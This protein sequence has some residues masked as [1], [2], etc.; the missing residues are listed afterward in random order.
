M[1]KKKLTE[2]EEDAKAFESILNEENKKRI[3][4]ILSSID[5]N[6]CFSGRRAME[7]LKMLIGESATSFVLNML[8]SNTLD[9]ITKIKGF[10]PEAQRYVGFLFAKYA[11]KLYGVLSHKKFDHPQMWR[12]IY[13]FNPKYDPDSK[14]FLITMEILQQNGERLVLENSIDDLLQLFSTAVRFVVDQSSKMIKAR[15]DL[16]V[17]ESS[18]VQLRKSVDQLYQ[19]VSKSET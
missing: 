1:G 10:S 12:S 7:S 11:Y 5:E 16:G 4:E 19:V 2:K 15:K 13:F 14:E 17:R 3:E 6:S 8:D 18:I 9:N